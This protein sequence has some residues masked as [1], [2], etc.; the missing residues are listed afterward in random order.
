MLLR[1]A[2]SDALQRLLLDRA[3][4]SRSNPPSEDLGAA[5]GD[6]PPRGDSF[7]RITDDSRE[8]QPGE[9][10]DAVAKLEAP[11]IAAYIRDHQYACRILK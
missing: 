8:A 9:A 5:A 7:Y 10:M 4:G 2:P 3:V 11:T 6:T 1:R